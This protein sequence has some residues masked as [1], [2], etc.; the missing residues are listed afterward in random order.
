MARKTLSLFFLS[1]ISIFIGC[2][3]SAA[4]SPSTQASPQSS[5]TPCI[6]CSGTVFF[7]DSIF[8]N[9]NLPSYFPNEPY[10]NGGYFGQ[11][12]DQ[13]LARLPKVLTGEQVCSGFDGTPSTLTCGPLNPPATVVIY[14]GWNNLLQ[15]KDPQQAANDIES[16]V[17]ICQAAGVRPVITTLYHIDP[18]HLPP[19]NPTPMP[20]A[21]GIELGII[22]S[23]I[24]AV[25]TRNHVQL[26]DLETIFHGQAGYTSDGIHPVPSG[27]VQMQ[28]AY[29]PVL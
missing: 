11:R 28:T 22:N 5:P 18:A 20:E 16:M 19:W 13:Q 29:M 25:A 26:V 6:N 4:V 3:G 7:G 21:F 23:G 8:G 24:R 15:S 12:T 2:G 17:H 9:W 27:Y 14:L 10:V 1:A